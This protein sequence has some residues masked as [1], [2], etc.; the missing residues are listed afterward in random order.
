MEGSDMAAA[1]L[2]SRGFLYPF[3]VP[4]IQTFQQRGFTKTMHSHISN[5]FYH[6]IKSSGYGYMSSTLPADLRDRKIILF[7][8][9][10]STCET[11]LESLETLVFKFR[12]K[13]TN[14]LLPSR[15]GSVL[16]DQYDWLSHS[17]SP[18]AFSGLHRIKEEDIMLVSFVS[19]PDGVIKLNQAFPDVTCKQ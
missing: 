14:G 15:S 1:D 17:L 19:T 7:S 5:L 2:Y 4:C 11:A 8:P 3:S 13:S 10:I 16:S 12:Y 9:V 6:Q 18:S